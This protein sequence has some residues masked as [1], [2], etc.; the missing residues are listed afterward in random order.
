MSP[1]IARSL[2]VAGFGLEIVSKVEHDDLKAR[3]GDLVRSSLD[4]DD[5][6]LV[7]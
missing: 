3:V 4:R 7:A 1:A 6:V 2:L 5:V